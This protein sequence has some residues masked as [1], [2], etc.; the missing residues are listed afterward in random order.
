VVLSAR[1]RIEQ[2]QRDLNRTIRR[3]YEFEPVQSTEISYV[4][5][6]QDAGFR[7]L[8]GTPL[9]SNP[10]VTNYTAANS[11]GSYVRKTTVESWFSG[12]FRY[13]NADLDPVLRDLQEFEA[14]A[15]LLL[16]TRIDPEVLWNLQPWSWLADWFVNFGD[17]LGNISAISFDHQVMQYGYIMSTRTAEEEWTTPPLYGMTG[18]LFTTPLAMSLGGITNFRTTTR[19]LRGSAYPFGFGLDP[20]TFTMEQWAILASLGITRVK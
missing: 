3:R 8:G 10:M 15:N 2:Y 7:P 9:A 6:R 5:V 4:D 20:S 14:H 1:K 18:N 16:G 12:A 19:K 17:V 11:Q 13:F